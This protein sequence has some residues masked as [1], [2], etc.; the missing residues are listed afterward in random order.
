MRSFSTSIS[1]IIK[2]L[3]VVA[4]AASSLLLLAFGPRAG[5]ELP[6]DCVI[7]D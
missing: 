2:T 7:V 1:T 3:I 4:L 5:D 6:G